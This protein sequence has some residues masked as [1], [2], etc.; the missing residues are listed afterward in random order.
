[1]LLI[2][3]ESK[4]RLKVKL[5]RNATIQPP[6]KKTKPTETVCWNEAIK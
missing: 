3:V 2:V 6:N 4:T 5:M 1:M